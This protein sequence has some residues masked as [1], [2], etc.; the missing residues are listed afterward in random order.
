MQQYC[1]GLV[2]LNR[3][4]DHFKMT[5]LLKASWCDRQKHNPGIKW[6]VDG[7]APDMIYGI[8]G[9]KNF[10]SSVLFVS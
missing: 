8:A 1:N 4:E 6:T 10:N 2:V 7:D 3:D 5:K 9:E